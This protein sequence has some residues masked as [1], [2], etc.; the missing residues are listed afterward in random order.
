MDFIEKHS[1]E[2][3]NDG[4]LYKLTW[5]TVTRIN[6]KYRY[7]IFGKILQVKQIGILDFVTGIL[8]NIILA[9]Q[10]LDLR[11]MYMAWGSL[12]LLFLAWNLIILFH[13]Y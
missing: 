2:H 1:N 9:S 4:T 10:L 13:Y 7:G 11:Q 8:L 3:Y 12:I 5:L 6:K